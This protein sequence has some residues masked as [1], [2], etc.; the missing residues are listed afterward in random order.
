MLYPPEL[1]GRIRAI[2][3]AETPKLDASY[4]NQ[5]RVSAGDSAINSAN[6][7]INLLQ[8][9]QEVQRGSTGNRARGAPFTV[10]KI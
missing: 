3:Q 8:L 10:A 7:L 9:N 5:V 4:R 2:R 1:R 6:V